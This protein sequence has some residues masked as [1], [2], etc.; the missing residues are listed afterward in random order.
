MLEAIDPSNGKP[1]RTYPE[2]S[3]RE[4]RDAL[5]RADRAYRAW[6]ETTFPERARRMHGAAAVLRR[7]A[8]EFGELMTREMG[9]P[10]KDAR[11]EVEKCAA[12]C[13]YFAD[14]AE[15]MLAPESAE[16]DA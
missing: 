8:G 1:L 4:T 15:A 2:M 7:R 16:T 3:D 9:K 6:R 12:A 14:H 13:A 5:E 11:A 10:I